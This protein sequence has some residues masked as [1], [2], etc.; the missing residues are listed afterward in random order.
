MVNSEILSRLEMFIS[1]TDISMESANRL[2]VLIDDAFPDGDY[3]QETVEFLAC[4]RPEGGSG[5]L[6]RETLRQR[7]VETKPYLINSDL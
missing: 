5:V 7:L 2:E 6:G 1:G 3:L 4:Y